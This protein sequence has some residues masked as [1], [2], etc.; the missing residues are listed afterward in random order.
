[1]ILPNHNTTAKWLV[2]GLAFSFRHNSLS[3]DDATSPYKTISMNLSPSLKHSLACPKRFHLEKIRRHRTLAPF[4]S[5]HLGHEVHKRIANGLRSQTPAST[6]PLTLPRRIFLQDEEELGELYHRAHTCLSLFNNKVLPYIAQ[7]KVC[8]VE[9]RLCTQVNLDHTS[10]SLTGV[11]D[12]V[13]Q[14]PKGKHIID[15]KTSSLRG[16]EAQLKFYLAL[17]YLESHE[18]KLSA[19]AISLSSGESQAIEFSS[20]LKNWLKEYLRA[21]ISDLKNS[22]SQ[23]AKPGSHCKYC[24]HAQ[25]CEV[26]K[27][28]KRILLDTWTGEIVE[29]AEVGHA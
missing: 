4:A 19:E 28:P 14:T 13:M 2:T 25:A 16:S 15:W 24:P 6:A 20:E 17:V 18:R 9:Q 22:E 5:T 8:S 1:M 7:Y 23:E 27:A 3:P 11:I 26:S 12:C 10:Y 21:L 29:G